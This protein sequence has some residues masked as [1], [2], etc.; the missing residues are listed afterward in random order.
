MPTTSS[1]PWYE[2][3][4][5]EAAVNVALAR[6][7]VWGTCAYDVAGMDEGMRRDLTASH[8]FVRTAAGRGRS[9]GFDEHGFGAR[10]AMG[11][12]PHPVER[13][14]PTV[15]LVDPAAAAARRAV[16]EVAVASGLSQQAQEAVVFATSEAVANA[17]THGRPP[18]RVRVWAGDTDGLTVSVSDSGPGPDPLVGLV[19]AER[20]SLSGHGMWLVHLL[21]G[22]IHH[23]TAEDGYTVTFAAGGRRAR[24]PRQDP[25]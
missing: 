21:L 13:T 18:V 11:V 24:P 14:E 23:R 20:H 9:E 3:R 16:R 8:P 17:W 12:P 19:P 15:A 22:D 1:A 25:R 4:R 7:P 10:D 5:Y 2:W 6:Y